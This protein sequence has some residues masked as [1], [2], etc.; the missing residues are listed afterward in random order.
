MKTS[1]T[2]KVSGFYLD[3][4]HF[5]NGSIKWA[6]RVFIDKPDFLANFTKAEHLT[7][8]ASQAAKKFYDNVK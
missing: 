3:F 2:F 1:I 7:K 8:V 6:T 4:T 5:D